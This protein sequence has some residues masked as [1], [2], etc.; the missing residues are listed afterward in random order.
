MSRQNVNDDISGAERSA[1]DYF[2]R[3]SV[4]ERLQYKKLADAEKT[5]IFGGRLGE[6][7]YYD[8]DAVIAAVLDVVEKEL[9]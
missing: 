5:V 6:Y 9:H 8:M 3:H 1:L 4:I 7:K 2:A